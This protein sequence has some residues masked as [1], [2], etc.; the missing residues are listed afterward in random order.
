MKRRRYAHHVVLSTEQSIA[1]IDLAY[2][3]WIMLRLVSSAVLD[4]REATFGR[5]RAAIVSAEKRFCVAFV[6]FA[7]I[8]PASEGRTRRAAPI[9]T[10]PRALGVAK[11]PFSHFAGTG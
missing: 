1:A 3:G 11:P 6:V 7:Q 8:A 5:L 9:R 2:N 10:G 4:A